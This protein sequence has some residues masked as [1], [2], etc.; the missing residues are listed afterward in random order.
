MTQQQTTSN[1]KF[2]KI[3]RWTIIIVAAVTFDHYFYT[4]ITS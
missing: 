2:R 1:T 3:I 4:F